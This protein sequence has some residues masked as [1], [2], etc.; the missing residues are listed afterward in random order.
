MRRSGS[1]RPTRCSHSIARARAAAPR[2]AVWRSITSMIWRPT[3]STGFRLVEGSWKMMLM[4]RPRRSRMRASGNSAMSV[5]ARSMRPCCT[6]P[7]SGNSRRIDSAVIDLPQPDS[8]TSAKV[9]PRVSVSDSAS[10]AC[11]S[12]LSV[13]RTV[14]RASTVSTA[15]SVACPS[16]TWPP[17]GARGVAGMPARADRRPRAPHRRTGSPPAPAP[18]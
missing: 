13:S 16:F 18:A 14:S 8:P 7:L 2:R 12:P 10:T 6:R 3:V 11:T 15:V 9:S 17:S 4:R 5:P 1:G